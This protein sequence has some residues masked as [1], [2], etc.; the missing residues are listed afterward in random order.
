[1]SEEKKKS[2]GMRRYLARVLD[3]LHAGLKPG[4]YGRGANEIIPH[5]TLNELLKLLE[6]SRVAYLDTE[7]SKWH[8]IWHKEK[9]DILARHQEFATWDEFRAKLMHSQ[10]LIEEIVEQKI[11]NIKS[12]FV[13][14]KEFISSSVWPMFLQ[15]INEKYPET[16]KQYLKWLEQV[17]YLD[18]IEKDFQKTIKRTFSEH[19]FTV[20]RFLKK[21]EGAIEISSSNRAS[22]SP[23][24]IDFIKQL[25]HIAVDDKF[26]NEIKLERSEAGLFDQFNHKLI[27]KDT[28]LKRD[29]EA[30]I[31]R[32]ITDTE[33]ETLF[34]EIERVRT[35]VRVLEARLSLDIAQI[36][37][38][39]KLGSPLWGTCD[40]C[41]FTIG[42]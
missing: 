12:D 33:L 14:K 34:S 19:D 20:Q 27:T 36:I 30:L 37:D 16:H 28:N 40:A 4:D 26:K 5:S 2:G 1:M 7:D 6:A 17:D 24:F 18:S 10:K 25:L 9:M 39:I 35:D 22:V 15:H 8:Y 41:M 31:Q 29:L 13:F 32:C 21:K 42:R 23:V 3:D 11:E 38:K